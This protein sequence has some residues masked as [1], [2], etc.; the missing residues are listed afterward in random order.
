MVA[1]TLDF[2]AQRLV[3]GWALEDANRS[4]EEHVLRDSR[5][6]DAMIPNGLWQLLSLLVSSESLRPWQEASNNPSL[7]FSLYVLE[8]S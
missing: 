5:F 1:N 3:M 7:S 4:G 2:V 8:E 6:L